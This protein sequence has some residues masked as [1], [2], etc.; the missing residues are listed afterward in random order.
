MSV[1]TVRG[2]YPV[3]GRLDN[4]RFTALPSPAR[5]EEPLPAAW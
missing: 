3:F 5:S 4:G 2:S 1:L